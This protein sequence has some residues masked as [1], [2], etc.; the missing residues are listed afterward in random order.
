M[1]AT[2]PR[3][4]LALLAT[5]LAIAPIAAADGEDASAPTAWPPC[6]PFQYWLTPPD[7]QLRPECL[8]GPVLDN[9]P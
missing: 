9:F 6:E 4:A 3:L 2:L 7:Y 8:S 5:M 1:N